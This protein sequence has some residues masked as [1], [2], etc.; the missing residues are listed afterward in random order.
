MLGVRQSAK[1]QESVQQIRLFK[2]E[3]VR[4]TIDIPYIPNT[5]GYFDEGGFVRLVAM[6]CAL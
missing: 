3:I 4:G 1:W 2:Q 6:L 5:P